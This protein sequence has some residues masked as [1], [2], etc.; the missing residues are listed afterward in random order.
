MFQILVDFVVVVDQLRS[1]NTKNNKSISCPKN[2]RL[3]FNT[4]NRHSNKPSDH[5]SSE[6]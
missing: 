2:W 3:S 1:L 4:D 5:I 6:I